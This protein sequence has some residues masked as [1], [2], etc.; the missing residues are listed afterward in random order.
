MGFDI[1]MGVLM[2][3]CWFGITMCILIE[4]GLVS[5]NHG[6]S[7]KT[8]GFDTTIAVLMNH[9]FHIK[10]GVLINNHAS[11][12]LYNYNQGVMLTQ[13]VKGPAGQASVHRV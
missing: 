11:K 7:Y 3:S 10:M 1:T 9:G 8:M 6:C 4:T 13:S 12:I 5:H 2:M